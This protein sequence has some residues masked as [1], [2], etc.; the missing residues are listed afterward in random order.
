MTTSPF[1]FRMRPWMPALPLLLVGLA[2]AVSAT[3]QDY[4]SQMAKGAKYVTARNY[5]RALDAFIGAVRA[6]PSQMDAYFN[7]GNIANH[8]GQ[9]RESVL[10]FRGFLYL[11]SASQNET[12]K[13]DIKTAEDSVKKCESKGVLGKATIKTDPPGVEVLVDGALV[14]KTP[15]VDLKLLEGSY[16]VD[17]RHP[18]YEDKSIDL[19]LKTGPEPIETTT[20]LTRKVMFGFLELKTVPP[21]GVKVR[22]DDQDLGET[23]LQRMRLE[24]RKYLLK[25]EKAGFTEWVRYVTITKDKTQVVTA[26]LEPAEP[27]PPGK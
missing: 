2:T 23:P 12:V 17:F 9:C 27:T 7:V 26:T 11:A 22:L 10:Y 25:L 19:V 16:R 8:L 20:P 5:P 4:T 24:T 18:E 3:A 14:G 15:M 13:A 1:P 21:D 6:D